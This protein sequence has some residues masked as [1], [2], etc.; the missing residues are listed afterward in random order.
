MI[1]TWQYHGMA[2]LWLLQSLKGIVNKIWTFYY[3]LLV[4]LEQNLNFLLLAYIGMSN[5]ANSFSK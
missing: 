1:D 2:I 4:I 5:L 3:W